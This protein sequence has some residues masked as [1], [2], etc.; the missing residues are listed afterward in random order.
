MKTV[1]Q[2]CAWLLLLAA[3]GAGAVPL[4]TTYQGR[5]TDAQGQ[6]VADGT[7]QVQFRLYTQ[8]AG[9]LPAVWNYGPVPVTTSGGVF[10]AALP[11]TPTFLLQ[12]D[13]LYLE[14]LVE[15]VPLL[16]RTPLTSSPYALRAAVADEVP[17]GSITAEKLSPSAGLQRASYMTGVRSGLPEGCRM[18]VLLDEHPTDPPA[19]L[20]APYEEKMDVIEHRI[21]DPQGREVVMKIPGEPH[22]GS[23]VLQRVFSQNRSWL[24]W[25]MATIDGTPIS[26]PVALELRQQDGTVI[27]RWSGTAAWARSYTLKLTDDGRPLEEI[28][29]EFNQS[30]RLVAEDSRKVSARPVGVPVQTGLT[31][32]L[33]PDV[34][35]GVVIDGVEHPRYV[36]WADVSLGA[37]VVEH[38]IVLPDGK[39]T[40]NKIPGKREFGDAVLARSPGA[41]RMLQEWYS[42][43][44]GGTV[45][46]EDVLL[47]LDGVV[48][49]AALVLQNCWPYAY[50]LFLA[51]DG[52]PV[53][54]YSLAVES[55]TA[56]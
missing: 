10:T 3:A 30:G 21:V 35:Y 20:G 52:L 22:W 34:A 49:D 16:P 28:A 9:A 46:R 13:A 17:D 40:V 31:S 53:E 14:T 48:P 42:M 25:V 24:E 11:L 26:K 55:A 47:T 2:L 56:P 51:D 4:T 38:K 50:K 32:S 1:S 5:L 18:V 27:C 8:A 19:R 37:S 36:V 41:D 7:H 15:G 45:V 43:L 12:H 44:Q 6:A 54:Q 39:I 29:M 33:R 23:L